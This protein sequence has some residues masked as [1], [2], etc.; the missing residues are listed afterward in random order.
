[1][2][3]P[4]QYPII[5]VIMLSATLVA[6]LGFAGLI[7]FTAYG[8]ND[9]ERNF[10]SKLNIILLL[11]VVLAICYSLIVGLSFTTFVPML[12]FPLLLGFVWSL[13]AP[14]TRIL[15]NVPL[16]LLVLLGTYRVAGAVFLYAYYQ[17]NLL[18]YGFAFN[19]GWGDVL[20]GVLAPIVAYLIYKRASVAFSVLL[21]WTIIGIGDLILAP[22]S[23]GIY[24]AERLVDFP[25]NLVPLFL[26]PPFGILLHVITLRAAFL[27][28]KRF[29][30]KE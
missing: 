25:L 13:S 2:L 1:M 6:L 30:S 26:G 10:S 16:Y 19:A 14:A 28:R 12:A 4:I 23:A 9:Q 29:L 7:R 17:N 21:I 8:L 11:W 20:T 18:S 15:E 3:S 5:W 24:G 27:Q 22:I